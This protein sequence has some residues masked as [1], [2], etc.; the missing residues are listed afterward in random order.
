VRQNSRK[1]KR[2]GHHSC[3]A[4]ISLSF[5]YSEVPLNA[6]DCE[7]AG[8]AT[9]KFGVAAL[10]PRWL[11]VNRTLTVHFAPIARFAGQLLFWL[12][13]LALLPPKFMPLIC[14]GPV[15]LLDIDTVW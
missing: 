13:W 3:P 9:I 1:E 8:L 4:R 10:A 2:A 6:T 11:G 14:S 15:P 12:N 7:A 5:G